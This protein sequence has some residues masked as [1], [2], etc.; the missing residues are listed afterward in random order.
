MRK[1]FVLKKQTNEVK[2]YPEKEFENYLRFASDNEKDSC[3]IVEWSRN[4]CGEWLD[5]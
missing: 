4:R 3:R 5:F 1:Y 2:I